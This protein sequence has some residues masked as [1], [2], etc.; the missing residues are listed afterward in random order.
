[1]VKEKELLHGGSALRVDYN[2]LTAVLIEAV[3]ELK[4][5]IEELKKV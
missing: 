2:K 3:K 4:A 5:E 1:M